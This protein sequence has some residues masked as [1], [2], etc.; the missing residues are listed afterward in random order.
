MEEILIWFYYDKINY[1][2]NILYDY[3]LVLKIYIL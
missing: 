3:F 1:A 2:Y